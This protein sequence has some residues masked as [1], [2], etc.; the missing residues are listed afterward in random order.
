MGARV[1]VAEIGAAL[2]LIFAAL[3]AS[4]PRSPAPPPAAVIE[5]GGRPDDVALAVNDPDAYAW[6]LFFYLNRPAAPGAAGIV[7]PGRSILQYAPDTPVVWETWALV[8]GE[9][10]T[11][12]G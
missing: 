9:G 6:R 2:A 5:P 12:A 1:L 4:A 3:V 8:S 7:D 10:Q 11:Q